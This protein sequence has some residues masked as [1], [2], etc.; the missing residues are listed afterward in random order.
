MDEMNISLCLD[1][2]SVA[3]SLDFT[4]GSRLVLCQLEPTVNCFGL[5]PVEEPFL[6]SV[7]QQIA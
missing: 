7:P 2:G 6:H 4:D 1:P 5:K 3:S